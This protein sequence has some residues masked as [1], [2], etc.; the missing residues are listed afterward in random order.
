V[1]ILLFL[2]FR[3]GLLAAIVG[4]FFSTILQNCPAT[5]DASGWYAGLMLL[6]IA[7]TGGLALYAVRV[8]T[9][10]VPLDRTRMSGR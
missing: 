1:G 9:A 6:V 2:L 8:A 7:V 3:F 10:G 5:S 4:V